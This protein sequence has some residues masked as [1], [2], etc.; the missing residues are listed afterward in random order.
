LN[1][2]IL[3]LTSLPV[4]LLFLTGCGGLTASKSISPASFFL[5]G[6]LKADP[7]PADPDSP[8]PAV[9]PGIEVAQF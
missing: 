9:E 3:R 8:L 6:I 1:C 7:P 5:P 2:K 4:L